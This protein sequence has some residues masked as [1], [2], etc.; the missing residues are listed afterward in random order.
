MKNVTYGVFEATSA[1]GLMTNGILADQIKASERPVS[2]AN[3]GFNRR[4]AI[5]GRGIA[6]RIAKRP[7]DHSH[8]EGDEIAL[9]VE[10]LEEDKAEPIHHRLCPR[11]L[12]A[13]NTATGL[14]NKTMLNA[15][16]VSAKNRSLPQNQVPHL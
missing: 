2:R 14:A 8:P 10:I 6:P 9:P 12:C 13:E 1:I 11:L 3:P 15:S 4:V 7:A 16:A 5:L